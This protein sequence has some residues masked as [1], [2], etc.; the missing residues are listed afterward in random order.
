MASL[1]RRRGRLEGVDTVS[2]IIK[3]DL[4]QKPFLSAKSCWAWGA[5]RTSTV[6]HSARNA[7][8][9]TTY[10]CDLAGRAQLLSSP[11]PPPWKTV[12]GLLFQV[13]PPFGFVCSR[14]FFFFLNFYFALYIFLLLLFLFLLGLSSPPRSPIQSLPLPSPRSFT[15]TPTPYALPNPAAPIRN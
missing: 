9:V 13:F 6:I 14:V 1:G 10:P 11:L 5:G 7:N 15:P 2:L 4:I 12:L 3:N 8:L